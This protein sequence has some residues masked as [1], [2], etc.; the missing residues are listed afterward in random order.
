MFFLGVDGGGTGCRAAL[1]DGA[2]RIIGRGEGGPANIATNP[3]AARSNI[4]DAARQALGDHAPEAEVCAVL[5]LAG[6]NLPERA[7]WLAA[8]LPFGRVS[9]VSDAR[10]AVKGALG[11][12]DGIVAAVGTGSVFASQRAGQMRIIGGWGFLLGDE[13]SGAWIGRALLIRA[14]RALDGFVPMTPCL[15]AV[16]DERG[17]AP[18]VV[19]FAKTA[20][21]ADFAAYAPRILAEAAAG[22]TAAQ[23]VISAAADEVTAAVVLLQ[24]EGDTVPVVF[25]GGLGPTFAVRTRALWPVLPAKGTALDGA[26][27]L[28]RQGGG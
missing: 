13:G 25:L 5:G 8:R 6:A 9:V 7:N 20:Q 28:A 23:A 24:Q 16:L 12:D 2:G 18:A 22:D 3:E 15:R 17:G 27:W 10:I 14:L 21:P 11:D 1:A 26:L 19:D 4:L